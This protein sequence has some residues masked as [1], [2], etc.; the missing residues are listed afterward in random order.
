MRPI[1][2]RPEFLRGD[3][4]PE[5]I[6][7]ATLLA[8]DRGNGNAARKYAQTAGVLAARWRFGYSRIGLGTVI[9][10]DGL[11]SSTTR[12]GVGVATVHGEPRP[13]TGR[14]SR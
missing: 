8:P 6:N 2:M 13:H 5:S 12:C 11:N 10:R 1:Q 7:D 4:E 9:S 3:F 14:R